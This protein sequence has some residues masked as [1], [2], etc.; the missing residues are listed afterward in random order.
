M[1]GQQAGCIGLLSLLAIDCDIISTVAYDNNVK[2]LSEELK[3]PTFSSIHEKQY[4]DSVKEADLLFSV[5]GRQIVPKDILDMPL[6]G[7]V[8]VHPCLYKYK[9]TNPIQ[10]MLDDNNSKASIGIH[11]MVKDIDA[12]KLII[13]EFVDTTGRT[14]LEVYNELYPYYAKTIIRAIKIIKSSI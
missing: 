10:R 3:I 5:H 6:L 1:G 12:G 13:E 4:L 11:Y 7:C 8:N 2:M 14:V 9:G